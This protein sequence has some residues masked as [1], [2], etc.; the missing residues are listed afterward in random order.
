M[1]KLLRHTL[2]AALC[3]NVFA[4][5]ASAQ[6]HG[7]HGS[8][9]ARPELGSAA[10]FATDGSLLVVSKQGDHLLLH[11]GDAEGKTWAP[12]VRINAEPEAIAAEGEGR[13][14]LAQAADGAIVVSWTKPLGKPYTGEIRFARAADGKTFDPPLTVHRDRAEITHRF[15]SL[16]VMRDGRILVAWIDKRDLETAKASKTP[17][18][19][20]AIYSAVSTDHGKTFQPEQKVADHSCE[21]CR[22]AIAEDRDGSALL[23]WRHVFAPNERDHALATLRAD[24]T[25]IR[26]QRA[27]FDRWKIDACPHHGPGLAVDD[28]GTRHA[29]WFNIKDG[30]GRVFYGRLM[31]KADGL[32]VDG[33][34]PIGG[35]RAQHADIAASGQGIAIVWKEFDGEQTR[36]QGLRSDDGGQT[37]HELA[38][39]GTDGASSQPQLLTRG[40]A[41]FAFWRTERQ[42]FRLHRLP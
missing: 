31:P 30:E 38:L 6:A 33:Q 40:E 24:G 28:Q 18:R 2:A 11:R 8:K 41:F 10:L 21:C 27:T 1:T 25:P 42:G 12:P 9:A 19:G 5:T 32:T 13:P 16:K 34:R 29:V 35:K 36:L 37:F 4:S 26:V 15:D 3:L 14:K 17:Y 7:N 39:D 23:F 20:A 22:I